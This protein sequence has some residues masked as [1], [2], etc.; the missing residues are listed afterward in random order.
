VKEGCVKGVCKGG[1]GGRRLDDKVSNEGQSPKWV[2]D[3]EHFYR[4]MLAEKRRKLDGRR[5]IHNLK[6]I[7]D[8]LTQLSAGHGTA[9]QF[10]FFAAIHCNYGVH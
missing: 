3:V 6:H 9:T 8:Q 5:S 7:A 4:V 1:R 2:A 10:R